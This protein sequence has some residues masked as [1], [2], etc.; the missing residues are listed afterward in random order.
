MILLEPRAQWDRA[1]IAMVG[2]RAVYDFDLCFDV[3]YNDLLD[4]IK[5]EWV[6]GGDNPYQTPEEQCSIE[7]Q[8]FFF[9][10]TEPLTNMK[11][12]PLFVYPVDWPQCEDTIEYLK[13]FNALYLVYER[14]A[15]WYVRAYGALRNWILSALEELKPPFCG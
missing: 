4:A 12:G 6:E 15:R 7:A 14:R 9:Y 13:K 1:I 10:N 8:E 5:E 11:R 3:L 2:E